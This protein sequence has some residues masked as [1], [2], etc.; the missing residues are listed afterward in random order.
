MTAIP[1]ATRMFISLIHLYLIRF[2][3]ALHNC[4]CGLFQKVNGT[5]R[6]IAMKRD[7]IRRRSRLDKRR[8]GASPSLSQP[9]AASHRASPSP[10]SHLPSRSRPSSPPA[11]ASDVTEHSIA[12]NGNSHAI[13]RL[14]FSSEKGPG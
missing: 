7:I 1:F 4:R 5:V 6:P 3:Y 8:R 9:P 11:P 2:G 14:I 10:D 13:P 12:A